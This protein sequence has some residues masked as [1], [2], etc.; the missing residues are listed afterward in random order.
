[1][2]ALNAYIDQKNCWNAIFNGAQYE[3]KTAA[4]TVKARTSG[5]ISPEVGM[6]VTVWVRGS[7]NF[8]P[9]D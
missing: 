9:A 8:Y 3:V 4:G 7:V 2:K 5:P 1:M 6:P